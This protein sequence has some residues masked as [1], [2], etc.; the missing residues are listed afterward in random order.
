MTLF[1]TN[2][3]KHIYYIFYRLVDT[4][5]GHIKKIKGSGEVPEYCLRK[6]FGQMPAYLV[7]RNRKIQRDLDRIKYAE[8]HKESLCKLINEQERQALLKVS[9]S[10]WDLFM[11]I[12]WVLIQYNICFRI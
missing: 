7:K 3:S 11:H 10:E 1:I 8:E 2:C 5:D 12:S 6:D 9:V 4:R